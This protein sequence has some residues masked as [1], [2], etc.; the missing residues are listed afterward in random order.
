MKRITWKEAEKI[1]GGR[2]DRRKA[3]YFDDDSEMMEYLGGGPVFD[4]GEWTAPC[5]GCSCDCEYGCSC[6]NEKGAGCHECGYTGK[7][8][9]GWH[10]PVFLSSN[11]PIGNPCDD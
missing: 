10:S 3:Y 2:L 11:R 6:C 4:Y 8:R 9:D 1:L 5:S 7:R